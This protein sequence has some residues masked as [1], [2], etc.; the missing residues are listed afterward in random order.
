[1]N[2][3]A[4]NPH[5]TISAIGHAGVRELAVVTETWLP[6]INGV[7]LTLWR[8][9]EHLSEDLALT[10]IRPAQG[11]PDHGK[12]LPN[13]TTITVPGLPLP[14]YPGLQ[15]GLPARRR[16]LRQWKHAPPDLVHVITEGPLGW[17]AVRAARQLGIPVITDLHTHFDLYL[18][19]YGLRLLAAPAR[20]YLR[21]LHNRAALTLV[22]TRTLADALERDG[23]HD[24]A[25]L[26]RGVDAQLFSPEQREPALRAAWGA[27]PDDPV[28]LCVGRV[29]AEKNLPLAIAAWQRLREQVPG[30]R[31]VITG[32]G[33]ERPR[34]QAQHP[35]VSFTG[36]LQGAQL[37]AT[38]ASA[39]L[40]LFP[41]LTDTF[42]NVV[43][44]AMASGLAVVAFDLAAAREHITDRVSGWR[45]PAG[46]SEAFIAAV[47]TLG[48]DATTRHQ[49]GQGAR[50]A[51]EAVD[52]QRI[53]T[54]Y[55]Q[56]IHDQALAGGVH[57]Q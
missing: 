8:L 57:A 46:Q 14:G 6:E 36:L 11:R 9:L 49:L 40:F 33:P 5:G 55:E 10:I 24:L 50:A 41:S 53:R 4:A 22:P 42:G 23:F 47:A 39:D 3:R 15:V 48:L 16:L 27:G 17:S 54:R 37:A 7:S 28:L 30:A 19:H 1:M 31:L 13:S 18:R 56:Y 35:E 44:E 52:W 51:I 43:L 38:Y 26:P 29:A 21:A 34:L 12:R 2:S 25:V 32:D 20:A 45:V